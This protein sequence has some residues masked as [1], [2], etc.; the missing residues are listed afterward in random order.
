VPFA[1]RRTRWASAGGAAYGRRRRLSFYDFRG[2][3]PIVGEL[4]GVDGFVTAASSFARER[5][6]VAITHAIEQMV[7]RMWPSSWGKVVYSS[8]PSLE[9]H[10]ASLVTG[11]R[12]AMEYSAGDAVPYLD[13]IPA[14]MVEMI[15]RPGRRS[16]RQATSPPLYARSADNLA[17]A[18]RRRR[19]RR[20]A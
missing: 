7:W 20:R 8:W 15:R 1:F 4:T 17:A 11:K 14:G 18:G 10:V 9:K 16:R 5:T 13:R 19:G 2:T 3:N 12:I 6:A